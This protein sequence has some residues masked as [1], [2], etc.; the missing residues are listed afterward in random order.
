TDMG[1]ASS[2][3]ISDDF[4][5]FVETVTSTGVIQFGPYTSGN[6]VSFTVSDDNDA[7][8][9]F[10]SD[11]VSFTCPP[12][13]DDC[14][15]SDAV[16]Q[17]TGIADAASATAI[18]GTV[19]GATDSGVA[20]EACGGFT[21]TANDD[22]WYSFEA[23]TADVNITFDAN[24]DSVVQLYSGTCAGGLTV[25]GCSDGIFTAGVEEVQATGL[26][27]GETY[28]VRIYQFAVAPAADGT[29]NLKV[30]SPTTLGVEELEQLYQFSYY[31]NPVSF[32]LVLTAQKNIQ[33]VAVFNMLGQQVINAAPNT[34][35]VDLDMSNLQTGAYFVKVSIDGNLE[36]IRVIKQ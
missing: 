17:E 24:F 31:P 18:P 29:F 10:T 7:N 32:N 15:N 14:P 27:V 23:L 36:T 22:V 12:T 11:P 21:G 33:H 25:I 8:C 26:T 1:T 35:K 28:Y 19:E 2:L 9:E 5:G 30:W 20:A 34:M 6:E 16:V 4:F 3:T 13:N